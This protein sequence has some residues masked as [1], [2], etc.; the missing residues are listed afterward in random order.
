MSGVL[1]LIAH[2][3][4][5]IAATF[6]GTVYALDISSPYSATASVTLNTDGS[7]STSATPAQTLNT[8]G[9]TWHVD[10]VA[11]G[12][13]TGVWVRATVLS[14][15]VSGTT[16]TW[17]EITSAR[18]WSKSVATATISTGVIQL[19]FSFDSGGV[20]DAGTATVTLTA[21]GSA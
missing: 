20:S 4:R 10:G 13:G 16:G 12:R 3:V 1:T 17:L 19:D 5:K 15:T 9:A 18:T 8:V 14:G 6:G 11:A 7:T 2:S 21:E